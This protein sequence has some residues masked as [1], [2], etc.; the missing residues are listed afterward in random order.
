VPAKVG[1][2]RVPSA[3][4][5][6][7]IACEMSPMRDPRHGAPIAASSA[8]R[9]ASMARGLHRAVPTTNEQQNR[10]PSRPTEY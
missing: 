7:A 5:I 10:R 3:W 8:L 4:A 1:I 6:W 9:R 2:D